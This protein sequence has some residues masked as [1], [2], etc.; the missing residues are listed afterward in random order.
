WTSPS[1]GPTSSRAPRLAPPC[2]LRRG[3]ASTPILP[4]R[5]RRCA[6]RRRASPRHWRRTYAKRALPV[7]KARLLKF[8]NKLLLAKAGSARSTLERQ[9]AETLVE[10]GD[11]ADRVEHAALTA[12]PGRVRGGV[13]FERHHVA[14]AAP[15]RARLIFGA[16]GH[17]DRDHVIVG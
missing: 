11:L 13:D 7:G 15:G 9:T 8:W 12:G 4:A 16:I 2:S 3:R 1:S 17:L 6:D 14:L 10:L 5:R